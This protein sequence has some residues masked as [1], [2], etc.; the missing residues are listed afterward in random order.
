M[1][2]VCDLPRLACL[3]ALRACIAGAAIVVALAT[4][5][6]L[7]KEASHA[8]VSNQLTQFGIWINFFVDNVQHTAALF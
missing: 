6:S 1:F 7:S 4:L 5:E 2:K 3:Y 8:K